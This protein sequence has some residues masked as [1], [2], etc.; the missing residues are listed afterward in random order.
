MP[1]TDIS[2]PFV[3]RRENFPLLIIVTFLDVDGG[4]G[5]GVGVGVGGAV[6]SSNTPV[7]SYI[8]SNKV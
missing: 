7:A 3:S 8:S 2:S 5:L 4:L 1:V 6:S